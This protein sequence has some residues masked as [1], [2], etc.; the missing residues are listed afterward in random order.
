MGDTTQVASLSILDD[1]FVAS[2]KGGLKAL[3]YLVILR[4]FCLAPPVHTHTCAP[5]HQ[6]SRYSLL[7][8]GGCGGQKD[9]GSK[10]RAVRRGLP[11]CWTSNT[12]GRMMI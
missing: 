9:E 2:L 6:S 12:E 5:A 10:M 7:C 1:F 3:F 11:L 8:E 4:T